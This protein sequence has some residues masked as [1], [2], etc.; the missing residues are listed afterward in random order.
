VDITRVR[1]TGEEV[2]ISADDVKNDVRDTLDEAAGKTSV[3]LPERPLP[4][5]TRW[6]EIERK[7][8]SKVRLI[9]A[10]GLSYSWTSIPHVTQ[11]ESADM[12]ELER[13]RKTHALAVEKAGGRLT[14]S[15]LLVKVIATALHKF[16]QF[17]SSVDMRAK[18]LIYKKYIHVGVAVD[19]DRG[20]LVP[21]IK[22]ADRKSLTE[23]G[24]E[25][26]DLAERT[27]N[28]KI[29]P[30]EMDG[31]T[32]TLSNL[33]SM[34]G[35]HFTPII[36]P[37][38]VA[39]LGAARAVMQPVWKD[40]QWAPRLILPLALSYDHRIIDGADGARFIRYVAEMIEQPL[41]MFL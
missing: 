4:D 35:T 12:T 24:V 11:C 23:L 27:R 25:L 29:L 36:Y 17:N 21:V 33:G 5:F 6:G 37:P 32:F 19:T 2:R 3:G 34:G 28:H 30:D 16:P 13:F 15:V 41:Q 18:E 10:D 20:L 14:V 1:G 22:D 38:Q 8:M 9:T 31:G 26:H 40:N 7:P 39:I